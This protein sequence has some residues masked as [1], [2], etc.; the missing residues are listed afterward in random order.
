MLTFT[1]C[2]EWREVL[3]CGKWPGMLLVVIVFKLG[4][5]DEVVDEGLWE[6]PDVRSVLTAL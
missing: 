2:C 4:D 6:C 1:M 5:I 3:W